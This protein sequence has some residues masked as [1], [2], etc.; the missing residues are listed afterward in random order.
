MN[1]INNARDAIKGDDNTSTSGTINIVI[2]ADA[3]NI[4]ISIADNAGGIPEE[5]YRS[6]L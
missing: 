1:V 5:Y 3:S 4:E 6:G 2:S